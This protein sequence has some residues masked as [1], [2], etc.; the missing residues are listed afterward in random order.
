MS[1]SLADWVVE[2]TDCFSV[3]TYDPPPTANVCPG[4]DIKLHLM[5]MLR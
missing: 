3:D 2:Y 1:Y 5:K 4:Y